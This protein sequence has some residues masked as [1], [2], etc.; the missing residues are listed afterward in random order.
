MRSPISVILLPA[1][2]C[3]SATTRGYPVISP[4]SVVYPDY[5]L[6][7]HPSGYAP[8]YQTAYQNAYQNAYQTAYQPGYQPG[9]PAGYQAV[10]VGLGHPS[11]HVQLVPTTVTDTRPVL[12]PLVP[13]GRPP[14]RRQPLDPQRHD[15]PQLVHPGH[16]IRLQ[17]ERHHAPAPQE[18][19]VVDVVVDRKP[20]AVTE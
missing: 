7:Y 20:E 19:D 14:H 5:P 17:P 6:T 8:A 9:Y 2:F 18:P 12:V 15:R 16:V 10:V 1:L 3:L 4:Y 11:G 13:V